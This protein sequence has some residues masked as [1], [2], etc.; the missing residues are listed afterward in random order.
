VRAVAA[1]LLRLLWNDRAIN[2]ATVR[3]EVEA[4]WRTD[5]L[6]HLEATPVFLDAVSAEI[7]RID[8][9]RRGL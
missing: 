1:D 3:D 2:R 4:Y 8:D 6:R 7:G 9:R 5:G